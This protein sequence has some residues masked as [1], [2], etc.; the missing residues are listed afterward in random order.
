[1][2]DHRQAEIEWALSNNGYQRLAE[3]PPLIANEGGR[4]G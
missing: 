2:S 3:E 1:M 4:R